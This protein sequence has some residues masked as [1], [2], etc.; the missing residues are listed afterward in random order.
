MLQKEDIWAKWERPLHCKLSDAETRASNDST[1]IL[2][3]TSHRHSIM[4]LETSH[5]LQ[6]YHFTISKIRNT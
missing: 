6:E 1:K 3:L 2:Y 5:I 4:I